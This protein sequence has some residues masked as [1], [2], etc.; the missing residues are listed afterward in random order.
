M[1]APPA[2]PEVVR[3]QTIVDQARAQQ[4]QTREP[5]NCGQDIPAAIRELGTPESRRRRKEQIVDYI[6]AAVGDREM[7][8]AI[9]RKAADAVILDG[10]DLAELEDICEATKRKRLADELK[11]PREAT[12]GSAA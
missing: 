11:A 5:A 10:F 7:N 8:D 9:P 1:E 4:P 3:L 2:D 12:S 6:K